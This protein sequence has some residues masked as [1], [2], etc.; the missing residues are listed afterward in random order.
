MYSEDVDFWNDAAEG[1]DGDIARLAEVLRCVLHPSYAT[2]APAE[3]E[4][5]FYRI[6]EAIPPAEGF[7]FEK[8]LQQIGQGAQQALRD[9]TVG[10]IAG[11]ALPVAGGAIGTFIG[12]PAGTAIGTQLGGAAAHAF[13]RERASSSPTRTPVTAT[14]TSS[15]GPTTQPLQH[16]SAAAAQ[17]LQ[18]TQNP[19]VLKS[20][21]ALSLGAHGRSSIEIGSNGPSVPVGAF[22]N[23][24]NTLA[25]QA[26]VDADQL[27]GE[28]NETP[29][30][31]LDGEG[32]LRGDPMVP[33]NRAR[34]LYE[35]LVAAEHE[36]LIDG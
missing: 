17:L 1:L 29:A 9:P 25:S 4:E 2:A 14:A 8:A 7:N 10:K 6:V 16:G 18:L 23:L 11:A 32:Q 13:A 31:L 30:Y 21:V 22:M 28:S 3:V 19:D 12:G 36:R 33:E 35:T 27:L 5:A 24:L 20:L 26:V 15:D 34:V